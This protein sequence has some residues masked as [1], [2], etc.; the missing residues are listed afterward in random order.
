MGAEIHN[1][2]GGAVEFGAA[3]LDARRALTLRR[4]I[5]ALS[6]SAGAFA[7]VAGVAAAAGAAFPESVASAFCT[8]APVFFLLLRRATNADAAKELDLKLST[9]A[10][11]AAV[12]RAT[13]LHL[14][15]S[16]EAIRTLGGRRPFSMFM[17]GLLVFTAPPA[18]GGAI[19]ILGS[20]AT[21]PGGEARADSY[22]LD[23]AARIATAVLRDSANLN[24]HRAAAAVLEAVSKA[25]ESQA[26]HESVERVAA[27]VSNLARR[28][29]P[30]A[31]IGNPSAAAG[32]SG[33]PTQD[34]SGIRAQLNSIEQALLSLRRGHGAT[35]DGAATSSETGGGITVGNAE[36]ARG[37]ETAPAAA[38]HTPP[39]GGETSVTGTSNGSS[40][41][42]NS[43]EVYDSLIQR[44]FSLA[45]AAAPAA[46]KPQNK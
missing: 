20:A 17:T 45:N 19:W 12:D 41:A 30:P 32:K 22:I 8:A 43:A 1:H 31:P 9:Q 3:L 21:V 28:I 33:F 46:S 34:T 10:F 37:T 39:G 26:G 16:A 14:F 38:V 4:A 6:C 36:T 5:F 42:G 29:S 2:S 24:H 35:P 11:G 23:D 7:A 40:A 15:C 44:Y 25:G 13:T 27:A 18:I